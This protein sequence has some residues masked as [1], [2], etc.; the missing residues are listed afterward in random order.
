MLWNLLFT[1]TSVQHRREPA[2][3]S[4]IHYETCVWKCRAKEKSSHW[5]ADQIVDLSSGSFKYKF[6]KILRNPERVVVEE[7]LDH[8]LEAL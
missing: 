4:I 5:V 2:T 8:N 7:C 6:A 3:G 1:N